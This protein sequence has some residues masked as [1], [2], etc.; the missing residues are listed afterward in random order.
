MC[1]GEVVTQA[2][3]ALHQLRCQ[4]PAAGQHIGQQLPAHP[5]LHFRCCLH[6][7]QFHRDH[8]GRVL[9]RANLQ[10]GVKRIQGSGKPD[11]RRHLAAESHAC[12]EPTGGNTRTVDASATVAVDAVGSPSDI[13]ERTAAVG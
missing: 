2:L 3:G 11:P 1:H 6:A 13:A 12:D 7:Q 9:H 10:G 4:L 5:V 8:D